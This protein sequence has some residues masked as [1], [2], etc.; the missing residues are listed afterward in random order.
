M[1]VDDKAIFPSVR[2]GLPEH[3]ILLALCSGEKISHRHFL[4]TLL[5]NMLAVAGQEWHLFRT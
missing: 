1:E 5:R 3:F 2:S 4:P